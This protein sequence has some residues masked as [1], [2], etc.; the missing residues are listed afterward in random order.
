MSAMPALVTLIAAVVS[1]ATATGLVTEPFAGT[2]AEATSVPSFE[3]TKCTGSCPPVF[4][5]VTLAPPAEQTTSET[6]AAG[7]LQSR[8]TLLV[9]ATMPGAFT[10]IVAVSSSAI[11]TAFVALPLAGTV[12]VATVLAP[13]V[14]AKS[15]DATVGLVMVTVAPPVLQTTSPIAAF[16]QSVTVFASVWRGSPH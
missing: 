6:D 8:L 14:I 1:S 12:T 5:M 16:A 9:T 13:F 4:V 3:T 2:S 15:I 10:P 11:A 7:W